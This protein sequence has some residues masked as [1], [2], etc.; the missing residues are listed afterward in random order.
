MEGR[1]EGRFGGEVVGVIEGNIQEG[2][3]EMK[4]LTD[5]YLTKRLSGTEEAAKPKLDADDSDPEES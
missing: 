1:V 2:L 5:Q 4:V 3:K